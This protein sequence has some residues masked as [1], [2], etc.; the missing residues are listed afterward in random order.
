MLRVFW[1]I[2]QIHNHRNLVQNPVQNILALF[3]VFFQF[4]PMDKLYP[5]SCNSNIACRKISD[6]VFFRFENIWI[7][8]MG[9]FV[10]KLSVNLP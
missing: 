10:E 5:M 7:E 9:K 1:N 4:Q 2:F 8:M 3:H 6:Q